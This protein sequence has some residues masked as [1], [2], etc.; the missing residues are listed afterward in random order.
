MP[1]SERKS[2]ARKRSLLF[3][4]L[5]I[6]LA[7]FR[8]SYLPVGA[9]T[10]SAQ[11]AV[12]IEAGG[13][14]VLFAQNAEKPMAMASTTKIM[15]AVVCIESGS[16][17]REITIP[18]EAVGIEGSSVYLCEGECLTLRQ[19]LY[20]LLL[21]SANDAATAIALAV[22]GSIAAFSDRMNETARRLGLAHTHFD[23]PH[24]LDSPT[25]YT[26]AKDLAT[27]S[28]Y[29]MSLPDF[30]AIV[31]TYKEQIP[32]CG[33]ENGRLLVNHNRLLR[34]YPGAVGI[35]TGFTKK[36]GRCLVSAAERDGL[37]LIAVTLKAPNDWKDHAALLDYGFDNYV[38]VPLSGGKTEMAL[39]VISG[40]SDTVLC[41]VSGQAKAVLP[42]SHG[43]I[44]CR[45]EMKR[46][47]YA[48]VEQGEAVGKILYYC[49]NK[50]IGEEII[51]TEQSVA[52][53]KQRVSLVKRFLSLFQNKKGFYGK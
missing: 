25:H 33:T 16:L 34:S 45:M 19:L 51:Y 18:K 46:F 7:F 31:S 13:G 9:L 37:L 36:S 48:P 6:L 26:T 39:P 53:K 32:F 50:K 17:D 27:L 2:S 8:F 21:S 49:E 42:Q 5:C 15:T 12:L 4:A 40:Q 20:A 47:V 22:S 28:S 52:L 10:V 44:S 24:G 38:S 29:A 43:V 41:S 1:F 11:S 35:K 30:R 23:N 14:T 3:F